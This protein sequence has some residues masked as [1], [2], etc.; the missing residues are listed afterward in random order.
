MYVCM[1]AYIITYAAVSSHRSSLALAH[2]VRMYTVASSAR[3][4]YIKP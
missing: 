4:C 1:Y 2:D 3:G